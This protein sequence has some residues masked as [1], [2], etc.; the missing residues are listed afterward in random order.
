VQRFFA[1]F[2]LE[3]SEGLFWLGR[4]VELFFEEPSEMLY[5][6]FRIRFSGKDFTGFLLGVN[7]RFNQY[8]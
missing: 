2:T 1:E 7:N 6:F 8:Q 5:V 3:H 4:G